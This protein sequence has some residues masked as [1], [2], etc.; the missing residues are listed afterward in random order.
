MLGAAVERGASERGPTTFMFRN[1][2]RQYVGST[3]LREIELV[4]GTRTVD[5]VFLPWDGELRNMGYAFVNFVNSGSAS[6]ARKKLDGA[7]WRFSSAS[8]P[9]KILVANVQGLVPNLTQLQ[10][11]I[12]QVP[13]NPVY[14]IVRMSGE[15]VRYHDA[16][17]RTGL[18]A[19][20]LGAPGLELQPQELKPAGHRPGGGSAEVAASLTASQPDMRRPQPQ[21]RTLVDP[22]DTAAPM[23]PG[24]GF[25]TIARLDQRSPVAWSGCRS[26]APQEERTGTSGSVQWPAAPVCTDAVAAPA[27]FFLEG[28]VAQEAAAGRRAAMLLSEGYRQAWL[29]TQG[30]L[31]Q[32]LSRRS[33]LSS[34]VI[35]P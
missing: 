7:R 19:M 32:L 27:P 18:A 2:P 26:W 5:M 15:V 31:Q 12:Q 28:I 29:D 20:G 17:R 13:G 16:L 1:V 6:A 23:R 9:I 4:A 8:K 24:V 14:P 10:R 34:G 33:R 35:A 25:A 3:L 11:M 22:G 30:K 21:P